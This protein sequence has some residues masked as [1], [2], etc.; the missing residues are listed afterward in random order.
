VKT[1]LADEVIYFSMGDEDSFF[2]W[3]Q[4]I[5][6]VVATEGVGRSLRISID[7]ARLSDEDLK[8][9][10]ALFQRYHVE[11]KQLSQ[12]VMADNAAW[13]RDDLNAY[14]HQAIFG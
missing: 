5:S 12:L 8:E 2:A 6:S 3:L 4:R 11:M 14:W 9:L 10:I 7:D 1:L 13:F